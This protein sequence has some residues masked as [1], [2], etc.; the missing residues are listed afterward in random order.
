MTSGEASGNGHLHAE[1]H[2]HAHT[3]EPV[4]PRVLVFFDYACPFCYLDWPRFKRLRA[5]HGVELFLIPFELRPNMPAEG[6]SIGALGGEHSER[7]E[8]H[9]RKM[10]E[11]GGIGFRSVD[12]VPNT[13]Y[14]LAAGEFARELGPEAH[15]AV[16]EALFAAYNADGRD[17]GSL[18]VVLEVCE[19]RG[20]DADE[21][22][23]ALEEGRYDHRLHEFL[24]LSLSFG[25][26][27]TPA[28][29]VCNE[30]LIGSRPYQ[31]LE[32]ALREC[33]I[34]AEDME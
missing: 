23:E 9:M 20:I 22:R 11:E 4:R 6:V 2:E 13:H 21:L 14:A 30:L 26:T 3:G 15:E 28:A 32:A 1:V 12:F 8:H 34:T 27:A 7:V 16:H 31:V 29:I 10:A 24:H 33:L 18:D 25:I 5:E 17:I 19:S